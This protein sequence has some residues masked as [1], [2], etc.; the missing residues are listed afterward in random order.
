MECEVPKI[1]YGE[2]SMLCGVTGYGTGLTVTQDDSF[3]Y[4]F[5]AGGEKFAT[6]TLN[7]CDTKEQG[8]AGPAKLC[9]RWSTGA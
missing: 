2:N 1:I 8:R 3:G 4:A 6:A 9:R 7:K 5:F